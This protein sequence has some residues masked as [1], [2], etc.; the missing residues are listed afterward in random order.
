MADP[1]VCAERPIEVAVVTSRSDTRLEYLLEDDPNRGEAYE[2]VCGFANFADSAAADVLE[3]HGVPVERRDI[4][5][6]YDERDA[7]L[8]DMA[9]REEFDAILADALAAYE[10][11]LVVLSGYLHILTAPVLD[12]FFPKIVNIHHADL[13]IRDDS[14]VPRYTGLQSVEDAIR[15][16]D[17]T[18]RETTHVVT[19]AVDRGPLLVRSRPFDVHRDLVDSALQRGDDDVFD[20]YVYAHRKW[21]LR[22]GGGR[23]LAKTIEL[24]ADGRVTIT[25]GGDETAMD[26]DR[27]YYQLGK[28]VIPVASPGMGE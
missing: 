21:M 12:R 9:V 2:I 27:G 10:P 28:G 3:R 17:A 13:T 18:T 14:G 22:E 8:D 16:G 26:G 7:D 19:E 6:F 11:D 20:A 15:N 4:H 5:D 1:L 25:H 23:T 24:I